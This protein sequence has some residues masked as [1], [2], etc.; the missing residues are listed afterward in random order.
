MPFFY[1]YITLL[2]IFL[3]T[4][5][6]YTQTSHESQVYN[7]DYTNVTLVTLLCM[8]NTNRTNQSNRVRVVIAKLHLASAEYVQRQII[9]SARIAQKQ[10]GGRALKVVESRQVRYVASGGDPSRSH[11]GRR[12]CPSPPKF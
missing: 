11:C 8:K 4:C 3:N 12:R 6:I 7:C 1:K 10:L 2:Q 5:K 9:T